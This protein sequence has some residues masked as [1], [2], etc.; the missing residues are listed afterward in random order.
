VQKVQVWIEEAPHAITHVTALISRVRL[1]KNV[2]DL[3][4]T[5]QGMFEGR[6]EPLSAYLIKYG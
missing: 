5:L 6:R 1:Q 4:Y 3:F 2:A